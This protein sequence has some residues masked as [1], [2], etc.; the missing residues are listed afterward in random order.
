MS[1]PA[2]PRRPEWFLTARTGVRLAIVLALLGLT[3]LLVFEG[4]LSLRW[5]MLGDTALLHYMAFMLDE[6]GA[7]PYREVFAT[8]FPG[9]LLFHVGIGKLA[10]YGD[11]PFMVTN[12]LW[13]GG[14]L[15][16]TW[17]IIRPFGF[18]AAWC[19]CLLFGLAYFEMGPE[20]ML[21]RDCVLVLPIAAALLVHTSPRIPRPWRGFWIGLL[22]AVAASIKPHALIGLPVLLY[23]ELRR[24]LGDSEPMPPR[25]RAQFVVSCAV[26]GLVPVL[27]IASWLVWVGAWPHFADMVWNYLPLHVGM[28][29]R[30]EFVD[31]PERAAGLISGFLRLGGLHLYAIAAVVGGIS[32]FVLTRP[33][34]P[35][36]RRAAV[37]LGMCV[38]YGIYP[39]FA[40]QFWRYHWVPFL[41]FTAL[42]A[43]LCLTGWSSAGES[44]TP[45]PRPTLTGTVSRVVA[46][47]ALV[48]L[49]AIEVRLGQRMT[50]QL[51]GLPQK[52][53]ALPQQVA[54]FLIENMSS[55]DEVAPLDWVGGGTHGMLIARAVMATSFPSDYHF[56]HNQ[57]NPRVQALRRQLLDELRSRKPRFIVDVKYKFSVRGRDT[58]TEFEGLRRILDEHY[59]RAMDVEGFTIWER[60]I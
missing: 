26:G 28:D 7:V 38:A 35:N 32:V 42:A 41:Y 57:S 24:S 6:H 60:R 52:N 11:L 13:L 50:E 23:A 56:Y 45:A 44:A 25:A 15:A 20:L 54:D 16:V 14:L 39:V 22:F 17:G 49:M 43:S 27:V 40:G 34:A 48:T 33:G 18:L 58:T 31:G 29:G 21:Q 1:S 59:A 12:L 51:R 53:L 4:A 36:R 19:A 55:E 46:L 9:S 3:A 8:S 30:H 2:E 47:A 37:V 10:G 5:R